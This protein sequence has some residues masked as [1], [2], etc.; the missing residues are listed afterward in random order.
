MMLASIQAAEPLPSPP[1]AERDR[2][3]RLV[4]ALAAADR[5]L[6]TLAPALKRALG[7]ERRPLE[8]R[9]RIVRSEVELAC[10]LAGELSERLDRARA[11]LPAPEPAQSFGPRPL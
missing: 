8:R 5:T 3:R 1:D 6:D 11:A 4:F 7:Y 10:R 2:A 9:P